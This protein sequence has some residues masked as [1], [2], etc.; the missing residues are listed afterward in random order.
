MEEGVGG[1]GK[2]EGG[3]VGNAVECLVVDA[4]IASVALPQI[5]RALQARDVD[6]RCDLRALELVPGGRAAEAGDF[7]R[8]FLDL[9]RAV[10]VV[11]GPDAAIAHIARY[12]SRHTESI[13]TRDAGLAD[14]FILEVDASCV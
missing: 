10:A 2:A 8:E 14:R 4:R 6:L 3:G 1:V 13:C 9:K 7:G 5:A 11:A 12:G